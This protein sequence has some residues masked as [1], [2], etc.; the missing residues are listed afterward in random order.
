VKVQSFTDPP[1]N[2]LDYAPWHLVERGGAQTRAVVA[3]RL[4]GNAVVAQLEGISGRE[5][6][7]LLKGAEVRVARS[8]LPDPGDESYYWAD[9][10]GLRVI[11]VDGKEL[12]AVDHLLETGSNDVLVV[13]GER[14]RLI[15]FLRNTVI[16]EVDIPGGVIRVDWDPEF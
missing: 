5:Q 8:A 14:E 4:H 16:L 9:L 1:G 2:I 11:T 3:A 10:E 12:G 6:A 7:Q 15:P 13:R